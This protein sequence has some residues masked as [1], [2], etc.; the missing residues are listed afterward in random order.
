MTEACARCGSVPAIPAAR[1]RA[2]A[3]CSACAA[4]AEVAAFLGEEA[5]WRASETVRAHAAR[6]RYEARARRLQHEAAQRDQ[7]L[8]GKRDALAASS[9]AKADP[10]SAAI[11]RAKSRL[12]KP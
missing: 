4:L 7:L 3:V 1:T 5:R 10:I 8:A 9:D 11:E 12:R 6:L 2:T